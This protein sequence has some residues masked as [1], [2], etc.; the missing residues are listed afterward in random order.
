MY[1]LNGQWLAAGP[2]A[3]G[4]VAGVRWKNRPHLGH[5]LAHDGPGA[6]VDPHSIE[7]LDAE[8]SVGEQLMLRLRL[9]EGAPL[10]WVD[11][12]LSR[13]RLQ[14][15][16]RLLNEGLLQR[17]ATHLRLTRRGLRVADSV[18]AELL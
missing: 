17:T 10:P 6:P 2:G 11:R 7:Q 12:R 16:A 5:Y 9:I 3:S 18:I 8:A 15:V 13:E 1:W 14:T 4:H